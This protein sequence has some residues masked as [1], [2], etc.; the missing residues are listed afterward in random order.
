MRQRQAAG[1]RRQAAAVKLP[2]GAS[3]GA[4]A[5]V[6]EGFVV[7]IDTMIFH[8]EELAE[9]TLWNSIYVE[10]VWSQNNRNDY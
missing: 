3:A 2:A 7:T 10:V 6:R 5:R 9:I 1:G 4:L 8:L